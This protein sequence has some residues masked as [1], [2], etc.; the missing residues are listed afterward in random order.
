MLSRQGVARI[1]RGFLGLAL[2][3][4]AGSAFA[5]RCGQDLVTEG[6]GKFDVLR[7]CG[8]PYFVEAWQDPLFYG[9]SFGFMED[10]Y[11]NF[12]AGRLIRILRFRNTRL[13][14]ILTGD[15]GFTSPPQPSHDPRFTR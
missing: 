3:Q 11:Y 6:D 4:L 15:Y 7:R 1:T 5:L 8:E 14:D 9:Q 2:L 13:V 10:W 12:G